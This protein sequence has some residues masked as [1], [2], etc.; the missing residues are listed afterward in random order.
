MRDDV[1]FIA[2]VALLLL[3]SCMVIVYKSPEKA[4]PCSGRSFEM[5]DNLCKSN[6]KLF[7]HFC[8]LPI[9]DPEDNREYQ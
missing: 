8:F 1:K 9:E 2:K 3:F 4:K 5:K 6:Q 7:N